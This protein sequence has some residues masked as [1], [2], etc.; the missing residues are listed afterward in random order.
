[1]ILSMD[2]QLL[3]HPDISTLSFEKISASK[4]LCNFPVTTDELERLI[5][6]CK[7]KTVMLLIGS[8]LL[9]VT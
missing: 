2:Y 9:N 6:L 8:S 3:K 7:R 1:M 5:S 4:C